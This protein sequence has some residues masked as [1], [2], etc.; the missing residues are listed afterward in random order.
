MIEEGIVDDEAGRGLGAMPA[1]LSE[2]V[3]QED[4]ERNELIVVLL[5]ARTLG[6][7]HADVGNPGEGQQKD[8]A[9]PAFCPQE[10]RT[11]IRTQNL[12]DGATAC[13]A[14]LEAGH[15]Y[16]PLQCK[17]LP[18]EDAAEPL[19][20]L[21]YVKDLSFRRRSQPD[22][23]TAGEPRKQVL[24][25]LGASD[26]VDQQSRAPVID[27][28]LQNLRAHL[29]AQERQR[30]RA[31]CNALPTPELCRKLIRRGSITD[32]DLPRW[33]PH[34]FGEVQDPAFVVRRA[35]T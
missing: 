6:Q 13:F 26:A 29:L 25:S 31:E 16:R 1:H 11:V 14:Q 8:L 35:G 2:A 23:G 3:A 34:P 7:P 12:L 27:E 18:G 15:S 4:E 20:A 32:R 10:D 19:S 17:A 28:I 24:V 33:N 30:F 5:D 9:C 21:G 22:D